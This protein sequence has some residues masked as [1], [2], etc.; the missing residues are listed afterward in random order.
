M[1][2]TEGEEWNFKENAFI[3]LSK[4]TKKLDENMS[5]VKG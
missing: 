3:V 1:N 5:H 2:G 4:R